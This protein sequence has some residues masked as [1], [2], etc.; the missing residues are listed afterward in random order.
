[1][2]F[3]EKIDQ[4][5][6]AALL[7]GDKGRALV[8]RG[9]KAVILNEEVAKNARETGLP[10]DQVITLLQKEAKKRQESADLYV[11]GGSQEKADAELSEKKIIEEYLPAQLSEAEIN[12][13]LDKIA[14]ENGPISKETMGVTIAA[15]KQRSGG[16]A[17]GA[18]TA[19]L[20]RERIAEVQA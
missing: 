8:L 15:V 7:G 20:V 14:A 17:D 16:S 9:I 10:D 4:D 18:L 6:K 1:M 12:E 13:L 11:S 2:N 19:K 3:K 5:L